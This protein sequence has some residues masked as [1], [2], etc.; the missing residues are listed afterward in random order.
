MADPRPAPQIHGAYD[1][2]AESSKFCLHQA[3]TAYPCICVCPFLPFSTPS[4]SVPESPTNQ[5]ANVHL[6][7]ANSNRSRPGAIGAP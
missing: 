6:A 2:S 4:A 3:R 1:V 5:H 7:D